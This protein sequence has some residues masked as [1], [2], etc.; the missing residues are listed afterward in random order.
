MAMPLQSS[1]AADPPPRPCSPRV[2]VSADL[3]V[4]LAVG[5]LVLW[6]NFYARGMR[7]LLPNYQDFK[8]II[9]AGFDP[10]AALRG[11]P[12]FPMWGY[13]WVLLVTENHLAIL[14]AQIGLA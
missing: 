4:Y 3:V 8:R 12:T 13:G 10:A 7:D 5:M 9:L 11:V 1:F 14:L 6:L 2:W